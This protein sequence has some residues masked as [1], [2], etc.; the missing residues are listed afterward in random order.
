M[1][2]KITTAIT[3]LIVAFLATSAQ[4]PVEKHG[5]LKVADGQLVNQHNQTPQ[6][7]GLSFSWS[8][9]NGQKYYNPDV[10]DWICADFKV[11]LI[12]VSMGVEPEGGY[13]DKPDF[14][15][16]LVTRVID[17]ALDNGV[18]VIID[19]HDHHAE[20]HLEESK[21]FFADMAQKYAGNPQVIYEIFNEP[22]YQSWEVIKAY[23]RQ[24]IAVIRKY[25]QENLIVVGS[26]HW[27]QDVD[28][29]ADSPISGYPNICYSFHF[30]ASDNNHQEQLRQ[31]ADYAL[32]KGLPL[33]VTEWG[34]GEAD[35][36][37]K[38]D[39]DRNRRWMQWLEDRKLSWVCWNITD[40]D[41]TTAFLKPGA[42]SNGNW[43]KEE[44][45]PNGLYLRERLNELNK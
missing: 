37:G 16:E 25:D 24:V 9:W 2:L 10:V 12:R 33:F 38:F 43:T 42:N 19:W 23:A 31:K 15:K 32:S 36:N 41:E 18:Y 11:S 45:T 1:K 13:L 28:V 26:P 4:S 27:D 14:Q 40:K 5:Q 20:K 6:L 21:A 44:L 35:G 34:V 30:Y 22:E 17:R 29:A 7:R 39:L 3:F 8:L